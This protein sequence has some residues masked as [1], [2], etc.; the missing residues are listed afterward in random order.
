MPDYFDKTWSDSL[1][2]TCTKSGE[3][4]A[5]LRD[6]RRDVKCDVC[7]EE[8]RNSF[9]IEHYCYKCR[10]TYLSCCSGRYGTCS[11]CWERMSPKEKKIQKKRFKDARKAQV[12]VPLS[13]LI[14][15]ALFTISGI[16]L[17]SVNTWLGL[18]ILLGGVFGTTGLFIFFVIRAS[19]RATRA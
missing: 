12:M 15:M 13:L 16:F 2:E 1:R 4:I 19:M 5:E 11:E 14:P 10:R 6:L 3:A 17:M 18:G 9:K 8:H 7:G